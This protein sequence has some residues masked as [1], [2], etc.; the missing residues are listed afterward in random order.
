MQLISISRKSAAPSSF[1]DKTMNGNTTHPDQNDNDN[2]KK[3]EILLTKNVLDILKSV[4]WRILFDF[5]ETNNY[6]LSKTISSYVS[7]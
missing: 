7:M 5:K 6:F 4:F 3:P 1:K 2:G